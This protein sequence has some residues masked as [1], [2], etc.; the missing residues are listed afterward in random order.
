M[1]V[2]Q[3]DVVILPVPF[4]D[5][6]AQKARPAI[7]VSNDKINATSEDIILVPLTS[8][9]K[10]TPYSLLI[11]DNDLSDGRLAAPTE[12]VQIKYLLHINHSL[13]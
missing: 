5:Q 9:L 10:D 6:T 12:R 2:K 8:V 4:S 7:V 13:R 11:T 1:N 3:R